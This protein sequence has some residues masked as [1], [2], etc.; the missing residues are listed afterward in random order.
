MATKIFSDF[1]KELTEV[2][3]LDNKETPTQFQE[4]CS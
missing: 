4:Y 2:L 3:E 1:S